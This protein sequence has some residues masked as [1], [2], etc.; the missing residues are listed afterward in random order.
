MI[1]Q[2]IIV[3]LYIKINFFFFFPSL[4]LFVLHFILS[5]L[6]F[7]LDYNDMAYAR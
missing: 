1:G 2:Q 6:F 7:N 3:L 5:L 4:F